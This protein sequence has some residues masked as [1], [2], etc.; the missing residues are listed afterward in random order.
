LL[1]GRV[2]LRTREA[3]YRLAEQELRLAVAKQYPKI[4]LG[5]T[6]EKDIEGSQG[7]GLGA[8]VELPLFDRNQGDIAAR[9]ALRDR[10]RA[11]YVATL[12]ELRAR[13]FDARARLRLARTEIELQQT[14][15]LPL[16]QRAETLF[17]SALRAR[18][19]SI[20]EWLTARTRAIQARKDLLDALTRYADAAVELDAA[21]GAPFVTVMNETSDDAAHR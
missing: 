9:L 5:P 6:Y 20:F 12:H 7:L 10:R 2:E 13:A 18:E 16:V 4:S 17:E 8:S 15:V 14:E 21:T 1:A 19:L 3:E 11:E